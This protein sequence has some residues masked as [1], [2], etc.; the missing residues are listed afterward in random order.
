MAANKFATMLH[1]NTHKMTV[2]LVYAFLEWILIILLLLNSMFSYLI[3]K[4]AD[5]F[6]LKPPCL[7]C[8][9]VDHIFEPG[10]KRNSYRDLVCEMHASEISK[11]G[12]CSNHRKLAEAQDMC[13][14]CSSSQP[15]YQ[16][17]SIDITTN[18]ALFSWV[19]EMS[20]R[21]SNGEK[22]SRCSCCDVK[23]NS[24]LCSPY[25]LLKPSWGVLDYTQKGNLITAPTSDDSNGGEYS[26]PCKSDCPTDHCNDEHEIK[27]NR[28]KDDTGVTEHQTLAD[29]DEGV[30]RRDEDCLR[31]LLNFPCNEMVDDENVKT[32]SVK[33]TEQKSIG[34]SSPPLQG[35]RSSDDNIIQVCCRE[36]AS[37]EILSPRLENYTDHD[38]C[39]LIPVEIIDLATAENLRVSRYREEDP[40]VLDSELHIETQVE[41]LVKT[42]SVLEEAT[43][44]LSVD[45]TEKTS[46]TMLEYMEMG[47]SENSSGLHAEQYQGDLVCEHIAFTPATQTLSRDGDD[48]EAAAMKDQDAPL[49]FEEDGFKLLGH[50]SKSEILRVTEMSDQHQAYELISPMPCLQEDQSFMNND[51]FGNS[52][53]S[54]TFMAEND[55]GPRQTEE[56]TIQGITMSVER[57]EQ[58]IN[59]NLSLSSELNEVEE[60][61]APE[62]PTYVEGLH[63]LHKKLLQFEKRESGVEES[64]DGS[65]ISEFEAGEGVL[66]IEHLKSALKTE[67]KAINALY[68]ELEEERSASAIAANQTMAMI[69]RLQEEKAAMQM[70]ALQYQRMMEEQSE[71]DQEALQL[72]NELMVK[73]EEEKQELEKELEM[74]HKK[75]L[76]YEVKEKKKKRASS[77]RSRTLS[78]SSSNAEDSDELSIDLNHE[79]KAKDGLY[80]HQE[81]RNHDPTVDAVLDLDGPGLECSKHLSTLDESV[82]DFEEERH[83]V[84]EQV[85]ALEEKLFTLADVDEQFFKDIKQ[86]VHSSEDDGKE[87]DD[88]FDFISQQI[89][90]VVHGFSKDLSEKQ[91]QERRTMGSKAKQLLP[92]FDSIGMETEDGVLNEEEGGSD[93]VMLQN[94]TISKFAPQNNKLVIEEEVYHV[95][96]RLQ[97]LEADREFLKHCISSLK[98]GD[99]GMDLLQEILE[100]LRNLRTVE[101]C[102]RNMGDASTEYRY[103]GKSLDGKGGSW[104]RPI[105]S[106][107]S[108]V[109]NMDILVAERSALKIGLV[110]TK[111]VG[112]QYVWIEGD[113]ELVIDSLQGSDQ[114][115]WDCLNANA[116]H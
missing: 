62:T 5:F 1:R 26:E 110:I 29:V 58:E 92:L 40:G 78:V 50:K 43:A 16:G 80:C 59:H 64:L 71:Y 56:D 69:T 7:C 76:D 30:C 15:N 63:H 33:L 24:K 14:D 97:A 39:R 18:I 31:S 53:S 98:K 70:E 17:K 79:G 94:S 66:T 2:I 11:L 41:L 113:S 116:S 8:S 13:E 85:K 22:D 93:T 34:D 112:I 108:S 95:Y 102:M 57:N 44:V 88:N 73:R 20:M 4:F 114:H 99:K 68:T 90:G 19:K 3:A 61:K 82:T 109:A 27:N 89:N 46:P 86:I 60:E 107:A 84:L 51:N 52:T 48:V 25:L 100:H 103:Y 38:D 49:A 74:Y 101:L 72:L 21:S 10:K 87:L 32:I 6:G 42:E 45:E 67:R 83:L 65:V 28:E 47:E 36:D 106:T 55:Q 104:G 37:L 91:Y 54:D 12:Y 77:R 115:P 105:A 23:L 111:E 81:S 9:R 96:E 35:T 75:V